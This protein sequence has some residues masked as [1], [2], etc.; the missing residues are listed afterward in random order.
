MKHQTILIIEDNEMNMDIAARLLEHQQFKVLKASNSDK[1]MELATTLQPD[2]I[3][4]DMHLPIM[5]GFTLCK[6][7]KQ[8]TQTSYIPIVAFTALVMEEDRKKAM[9]CG[10]AGIIS[11]P[12]DVASFANTVASFL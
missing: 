6:A 7:L 3:L 8:N 5:D 12:I 11:K 9:A 1:G 10:C 2:L 4:M